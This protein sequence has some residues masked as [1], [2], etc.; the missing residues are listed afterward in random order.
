MSTPLRWRWS[1]PGVRDAVE[2]WWPGDDGGAAYA[3]PIDESAHRRV[4]R[5]RAPAAAGDTRAGAGDLLVKHYRTATGPH[6]VRERLKRVLGRSACDRE[7][8][9]LGRLGRAGV[10]VPRAL[11]RARS[12]AGDELLVMEWIDARSLWHVLERFAAGG[13][14]AG[15]RARRALLARVADAVAALHGAS[16]AHGDLHPGNVLVAASGDPVLVDL[17]RAGRARR[18]GTRQLRDVGLLDYSLRQ[19]G[20]ARSDRLRVLTRA[21]GVHA[22]SRPER[23]GR[24]RAAVR[25]AERTGERHQRARARRGRPPAPGSGWAPTLSR[26]SR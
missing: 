7:A 24:I 5:L 6:P 11:G 12:A 22:A 18:G 26:P 20:V 19:L 4:L 14:G 15:G 1:T 13:E 21:L 16:L 9:A 2:A 23:R 8:R 3:L 10:A 17:Q 25:V